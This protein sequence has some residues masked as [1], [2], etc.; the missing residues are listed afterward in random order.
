[1]DDQGLWKARPDL[2][3]PDTMCKGPRQHS[4]VDLCSKPATRT[5]NP[6]YMRALRQGCTQRGQL[7]NTD[8]DVLSVCT[9]A[10]VA[11]GSSRADAD[12]ATNTDVDAWY[13][14]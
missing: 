2:H 9:V 10:D 3:G 14:A 11:K 13:I 12:M 7:V 4:N 8:V 6:M 1:V 5:G